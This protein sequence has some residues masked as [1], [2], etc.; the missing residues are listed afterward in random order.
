MSRKSR[1]EVAEVTGKMPIAGKH[2]MKYLFQKGREAS[3]NGEITVKLASAAAIGGYALL[4]GVQLKMGITE[5]A[6][7]GHQNPALVGIDALYTTASAMATYTQAYLATKVLATRQEVGVAVTPDGF[8]A[9]VDMRDER[10]DIKFGK[11]TPL[12]LAVTLGGQALFLA[13]MH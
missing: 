8:T 7:D 3:R 4:H 12:E 9:S 11:V 10:P 6:H 13:T 1:S 5:L 2:L